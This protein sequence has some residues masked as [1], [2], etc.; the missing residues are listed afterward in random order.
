MNFF[1]RLKNFFFGKPSE[2]ELVERA[3]ER[4]EKRL[5]EMSERA[6]ESGTCC[7]TCLFGSEHILLCGDI[8]P[9]IAR[10]AIEAEASAL[11]FC[12]KNP[13]QSPIRTF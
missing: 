2:I 12:L 6:R 9:P 13:L 7:E 3:L 10:R 11:D 8:P 4:Y 1:K 5:R